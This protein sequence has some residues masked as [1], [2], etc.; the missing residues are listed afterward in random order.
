MK[1]S[2]CSHVVE[3]KCVCYEMIYA[4]ATEIRGVSVLSQ[5]QLVTIGD[6]VSHGVRQQGLSGP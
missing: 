1:I 5:S 3:R 4:D 2:G 6:S